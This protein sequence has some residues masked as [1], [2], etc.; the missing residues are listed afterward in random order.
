MD[1]IEKASSVVENLNGRVRRY[2]INH[3]HV[4]QA[5]LDLL[6][7]IMNHSPFMRSRCKHRHGKSPAEVLYAKKHSHWLEMLGYTPVQQAA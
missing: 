4:S 3:V 6:R 5:Q 1:D 7:F 2:L